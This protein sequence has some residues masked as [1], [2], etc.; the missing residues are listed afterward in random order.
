MR[1]TSARLTN[2]RSIIDSTTFEVESK[3]TILVGINEA[4]K[5][6]IL[7]ALQSINPPAETPPL[8]FLAD[9]PRSRLNDIQT[10]KI[11]PA[12]IE[13][14][15]VTFNLD[16]VDRSVLPTGI[17]LDDDATITW[18]RYLDNSRTYTLHGFTDDPTF[19]D[20]RQDLIRLQAYLRKHPE[21]EAELLET[22]KGFEG[23][24]GAIVGTRM[25]AFREA[26]DAALPLID[27]SDGLETE[28]WN[29]LDA[30]V[31]TAQ[32]LASAAKSLQARLPLLVYYS[33]YFTVRPRIDLDSLAARQERGDI[34]SEYDF[35]N[36]CLL[37]LLGFTAREL[38]NLAANVPVKPQDYTS[39]PAARESHD[40]AVAEHQRRLD[41]RGYQ[42]NAASVS[43]TKDIR[44]V[45]GDEQITLR[46]VAD[47]QYLKV[48][49]EDDLG[50]EVELDQR[51][52]GFRWL[53][54]F[55]VVFRSQAR[56]ALSR[57]VL[58]LDEPG[59]SLHALKQQ[60]FRK[61]VSLLGQDN[62]II[63]TTHSPFMVGTDE[64]D[65]V[66]IV[67]MAT[68]EGGTKVLTRLQVDD[69]RSIYPLQAAL[70]YELG[71]TLFAQKKNLVCEGV[72]DML[73]INAINDAA[74]AEKGPSFKN[75]P[76]VIAAGTASKV[77]YFVTI[78]YGQKLEVAAL[79]DSDAAGDQAASQDALAKLLQSKAVLRISDFLPGGGFRG[80]AIEDLLRQT[81][82]ARAQDLGW[83]SSA[84]ATQQPARSLAA[85]L[86]SE[87]PR[88][89]SKWK[90]TK[91]FIAWL[92][93]HGY[94]AL[95]DDE[96]ASWAAFVKAVD[97]AL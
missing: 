26:L 34:D 27:E 82:I 60:E 36:L 29:R 94:A 66:R 20:A 45:W 84:T 17:H 56:E 69:P 6:A 76:A 2:Y 77:A 96:K 86:E 3:K 73:Y 46:V 53:V 37:N 19:Q 18:H 14:A 97:R 32:D 11:S 39:N 91:N 1:I 31:R 54:S 89:F 92:S 41:A 47:G 42:L 74:K 48:V 7:R 72:T 61:T 8:D 95:T 24:Q 25:T 90:L 28:R 40:R 55:F 44:R 87:H 65:L 16:E 52:E 71:Q 79:L 33:T 70:G 15:E 75:S 12:T 9:Y 10:G 22:L 51:S 93:Q 50:V 35:G 23:Q 85:I 64:L 62:Q 83:D 13:V 63:Y 81:L 59:L 43:L 80:A 78:Y 67:E 49:V 4:G 30:L 88:L 38:S 57:A 68:R 58:L 21:P 5:T